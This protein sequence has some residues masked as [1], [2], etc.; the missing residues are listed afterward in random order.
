MGRPAGEGSVYIEK[1]KMVESDGSN[2]EKCKNEMRATRKL[3]DWI[4]DAHT[5]LR[6][7]EH[8]FLKM[9]QSI[10]YCYMSII[11]IRRLI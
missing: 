4:G 3:D 5:G 1:L 7:D 11:V 8:P 10:S 2:F 9:G 6:M